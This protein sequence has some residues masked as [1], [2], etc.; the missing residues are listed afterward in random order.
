LQMMSAPQTGRQ[1]IA[2]MRY[3]MLILGAG[4]FA[5]GYLLSDCTCMLWGTIFVFI[6]N[7]FYG[8]AE[9]H[10]RFIYLFFH[11]SF[12][13]FL[14]TR[15]MIAC[16]QGKAWWLDY[17]EPSTELAL[18]LLIVSL[19]ALRIGACI[20][21]GILKRTDT[22][23][24]LKAPEP[25][26]KADFR[27]TLATIAL[28][29]FVITIAA[30]FAEEAEKLA[31][32]N[33]RS[34]NEYFRS[35][36]SSL[37]YAVITL[38]S[39]A[40]YALC[41]FL[42][43]MPKKRTAVI[44]LL[45]YVL[46][47]V[48][49]FIIGTRNPVILRLIFAII[50][51][52]FRD[53]VHDREKWFGKFEKI[54]I[55]AA[56]PAAVA[57]LG[58]YSFIRLGKTVTKG[59]GGSIVGFFYSQGVSFD[60]VRMIHYNLEKLPSS[61]GKNYTFGPFTDYIL[62]GSIGHRLFGNPIIGNSNSVAKAVYGSSLAHSA[63]YGVFPERYLQGWGKGSSYVIENYLDW[64]FAG[65]FIFS[66]VLGAVL[67]LM[68]HML[69]QGNTLVRTIV[70]VSLL[71]LFFAP[72]AGATEWISFLAYIQFWVLIIAVYLTAG[73]CTRKYSYDHKNRMIAAEGKRRY[74]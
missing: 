47:A 66:L 34:Y 50:Y 43:A 56:T 35:Y 44:V 46:N 26:Y 67:I 17:S 33:D 52:I 70:L 71:G 24:T 4:L 13:T 12:F 51:F 69:K 22:G 58:M 20:G 36:E 38:G 62:F 7:V 25:G 37:P 14:I 59:F 29:I 2:L 57:F 32:M 23:D 40:K 72:R 73:L 16:F 10:T 41:I 68:F 64:G 30:S 55:I 53:V 11:L 63:M 65:V 3:M 49:M 9:G 48:P 19:L 18:C 6:S 27:D 31:F 39:M 21:D 54:I 28:I 74:V 5:A 60:T 15:P 42:A 8:F 61:V 1:I 45:V